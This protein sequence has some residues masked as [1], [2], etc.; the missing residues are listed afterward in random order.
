MDDI[1]L[2]CGSY[3]EAAAVAR[4]DHDDNV[5]DRPYGLGKI[6]YIDFIVVVVVVVVTQQQQHS[7]YIF[8]LELLELSYDGRGIMYVC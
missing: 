5:H 3:N 8:C 4:V 7:M 2:S 1:R 6:E